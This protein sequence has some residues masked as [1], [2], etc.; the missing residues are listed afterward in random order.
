MNKLEEVFGAK[1]RSL[2]WNIVWYGLAIMGLIYFIQFLLKKESSK[3]FARS[4]HEPKKSAL[5]PLSGKVDLLTFDQWIEAAVADKEYR[6]A[7]RL[8]FLK[9]LKILDQ[10]DLIEW[11]NFKTNTDYVRELKDNSLYKPFRDLSFSYEYIW[12]GEFEPNL[13]EFEEVSQDFDRCF[14]QLKSMVQ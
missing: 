12:Y 11:K 7:I 9:L 8:Y 4:D 14:N 6:L 13:E 3:I 2:F 1:G 5:D 10:K